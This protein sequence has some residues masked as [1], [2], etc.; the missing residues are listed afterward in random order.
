MLELPPESGP[1]WMKELNDTYLSLDQSVCDQSQ[2][3]VHPQDV[4][5]EEASLQQEALVYLDPPLSC[6]MEGRHGAI[7]YG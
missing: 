7:G 5:L 2:Y 1:F 3:I 6:R 4:H